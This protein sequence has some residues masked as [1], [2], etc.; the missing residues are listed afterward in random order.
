MMGHTDITALTL[1]FSTTGGLQ[2]LNDDAGM[3][4]KYLEIRLTSMT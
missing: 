4:P 3:Y 1:L 2:I